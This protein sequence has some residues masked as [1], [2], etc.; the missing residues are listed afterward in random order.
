MSSRTE[1]SRGWCARGLQRV[2]LAL[3]VLSPLSCSE[4]TEP[5]DQDMSWEAFSRLQIGDDYLVAFS[6]HENCPTVS[7]CRA[8]DE[9]CLCEI[10]GIG[11]V[12]TPEPAIPLPGLPPP[13]PGWADEPSSGGGGSGGGTGGACTR[14]GSC[15]ADAV[16]SCPS[17]VVRGQWGTCTLTI[18]PPAALDQVH[19]WGISPAGLGSRRVVR[20]STTW[21]GT[22]VQS[23]RVWVEFTAAGTFAVAT[24]DIHV[25]AR[26]WTWDASKRSVAQGVP[27]DLDSCITGQAGLTADKYGCTSANPGILINPGPNKGF[28]IA[29]G[30]GPNQGLW[31]VTTPTTRMDVRTQL[32]K[33]YRSDGSKD[34]VNGVSQVVQGCASAYAPNPVPMQN[35]HGI[36]TNCFQTADFASLVSFTW[37]HEGQH[38]SLAQPEAQ[39]P[40]NDIYADWESIVRA[41]SSQAFL[42]VN[43]VQ[44]AMHENVA[45]TANSIH[46]GGSTPFS[47]WYHTGSG[48]W[49]WSTITVTH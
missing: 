10:E 42:E 34:A 16:L 43:V 17:G 5:A 7:S 6:S 37:N 47:F 33:K 1:L 22:L 20:T 38:M 18:D 28:T 32:A 4:V 25:Q 9:R 3:I 36:N 23:G 11:V 39:K 49:Q 13:P 12:A 40:Y 15:G 14:L 48:I 27:G 21:S 19:A 44:N 45:D 29:E 8:E 41:D 31:Y 35:N 30:S 24:A 46:T 2:L 26:A